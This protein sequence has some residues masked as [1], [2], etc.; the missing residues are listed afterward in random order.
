MLYKYRSLEAFDN[1]IDIILNKR[2]FAAPYFDLNDP[3]EG[4]YKYSEGSINQILINQIKGQKQRIRIC[5]LSKIFNSTLMWS[6]YADS[7]RGVAIGV[8]VLPN[9]DTREVIYEGMSFI[10]N[11]TKH[12]SDET[13][14]NILTYKLNSWFYEEEQRVFITEGQYAKVKIREVILGAKV[15]QKHNGLVKKLVAR[16]DPSIIVH[17]VSIDEL[18]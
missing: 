7:H 9:Q 6:H 10:K 18:V 11:A 5:S 1:F 4:L 15:S 12:G 8:D 17:K 14:K 13:A 2:I 3:M 16:I